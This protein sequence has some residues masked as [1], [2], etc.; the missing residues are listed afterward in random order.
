MEE[1]L[2][3]DFRLEDLS[4]LLDLSTFHLCRAFK[5]STGLPPHRWRLARRIER[6]REMLE[7]TN[8]SVTDIAAAVGYD[9][10]SQ[11]AA[12]F[13]K[14]LGVT[15]TGIGASGSRR[16]RATWRRSVDDLSRRKHCNAAPCPLRRTAKY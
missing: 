2:A 4:R 14:A 1:H 3:E 11:L 13:R 9:D 15:P 5:Q 12:V 10:P 6:A 8:R 7:G 16:C